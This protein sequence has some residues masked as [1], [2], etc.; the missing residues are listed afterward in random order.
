M[1]GD[2]R[3]A[4]AQDFDKIADAYLTVSDEIQQSQARRVCQSSEK[5]IQ[6]ESRVRLDHAQ[7]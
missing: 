1:T 6:R 3:L 2:F 5:D 4:D 7:G